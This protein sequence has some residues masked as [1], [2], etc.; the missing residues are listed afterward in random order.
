[1]L[2]TVSALDEEQRLVFVLFELESM[3]GSEIAQALGIPSGTVF[4]RLR[5]ARVAFRAALGRH[6]AADDRPL[7]RLRAGNK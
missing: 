3:T 7:L 5:L 2:Q 1:M 6:R 4:S